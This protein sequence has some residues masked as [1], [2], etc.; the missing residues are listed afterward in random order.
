MVWSTLNYE[1]LTTS[2][3]TTAIHDLKWDPFSV[4]EFVSV[5]QGGSVLFWLLDETRNNVCLNVHEAD[6]PEELLQKHG[7]SLS[8]FL[9]SFEIQECG[10]YE[11]QT[12]LSSTS[13]YINTCILIRG[14]YAEMQSLL[15]CFSTIT[16]Q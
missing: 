2:K 12:L 13:R 1:I 14:S 4:N 8:C 15:F 3:T 5:G 6:V 9:Y 10:V 7:V 11:Y 16:E